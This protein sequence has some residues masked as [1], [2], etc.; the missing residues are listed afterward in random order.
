MSRSCGIEDV[1]CW[2]LIRVGAGSGPPRFSGEH[3]WLLQIPSG[4]FVGCS[5]ANGIKTLGSPPSVTPHGGNGDERASGEP[6]QQDRD[7][8]A[9][10]VAGGEL[11]Y[12]IGA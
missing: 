7:V 10:L 4:V 9:G 6:D 3:S 2:V 8:V 11:A 1:R 12:S 5:V